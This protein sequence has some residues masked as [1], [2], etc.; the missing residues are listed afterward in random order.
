VKRQFIIKLNGGHALYIL[1]PE[2]V[3]KADLPKRLACIEMP[4]ILFM[5]LLMGYAATSELHE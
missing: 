2:Q 4:V 1:N 5:D 3:A